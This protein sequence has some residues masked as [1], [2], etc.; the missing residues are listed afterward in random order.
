MEIEEKKTPDGTIALTITIPWKDIEATWNVVVDEAVEHI[1]IPGFRKGKA[2]R[3][4]AEK[5]LNREK[6]KEEVLKRI[7]TDTYN[8]AIKKKNITPIITPQIHVEVF[9]EGTEL[10]Y[11]AKTCEQ[12]II[13]L[14]NYKEKI[15]DLSAKS[16]IIK[17]GEKE[18]VKPALEEIVEVLV[19]T[20]EVTVPDILIEQESQ[21]LLAQ[22]LD[23]IKSLG[24]TLDQY[25]SSRG[26]NVE[27]IKK[28]YAE[29]AERDLKFEFLLRKVADEEKITVEEKDIAEA[30]KSI[31]DEK[32]KQEIAQ[33]PYLF[34]ALI[35]Q[36]KTLD[37]LSKI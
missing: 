37:F 26:K 31:K 12:P 28:E 18:A 17:P 30:M 8:D 15:A 27:E 21:R 1:E 22:L 9:D 25:L 24:L 14:N 36:Q 10:K 11:T 7:V 35:R 6:V 13:Q 33:N 32:Q 29:R 2:P 20:G 34:A 16:K 19:K 3:K 5:K 4:I 23:E